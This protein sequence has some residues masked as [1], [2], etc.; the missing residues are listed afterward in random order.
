MNF[1]QIKEKEIFEQSEEMKKY[2]SNSLLCD[3]LS[4]RGILNVND[5]EKFLNSEKQS[6]STLDIF[7][8]GKK[9]S[10][11]I[12][13]AIEKQEKILVWG[14]F[15]ADGVTSCAL[16]HKTLKALGANFEV[17]IP[18]REKH[19]HGLNSKELLT[20]IAKHKVKVLITVDCGIS[21]IAE[22]KVAKSFGVDVIITDHH[23]VEGEIPNA[24]AILNP[25]AQGSL[26]EELKLDE[27][28]DY[29][30]LA[31]VGVAYKLAIDLLGQNHEICDELTV[32]ATV[33]TIS[34]VVPL[35]G[36]N[37]T[38]VT[39]GLKL[40]NNGVHTGIRMLFEANGR[41]NIT[42][43]DIAFI[44]TPR[45]NAIGRLTTPDLSFD[46]LTEQNESSLSFML[47]K[48]D[49][50]NK[51]RQG[52][53]DEIFLEAYDMVK[54]DKSFNKQK[55]IVLYKKGWH[56][57]IIGIVASKI[58][59]TFLKPVFIITS[60]D[61]KLARCSIRAQEGFNVYEILKRNSE[62]FE[63][64]GGHSLAGGFS[65]DLEKHSLEE[66]KNGILEAIDELGCESKQSEYLFVDK[67]LKPSEINL[68]LL[69]TISLLEPFGQD[70][71]ATV[72]ALKDLNVCESKF[73]GKNS[74]HLKLICKKDNEIFEC[75]K[76]RESELSLEQES[77]IDMAFVPR[78][79][80]FGDRETIQLEICDI[81]SEKLSKKT[82]AKVK[83]YDHRQKTGILK[84]ISDYL[85]GKDQDIAVWAKNLKTTNIL[86]NY[87]EIEKKYYVDGE[88]P[89]SIMFFDYPASY[90]NFEE[91]I[92]KIKPTKIHLMKDE[93]GST[94]EDTINTIKGMVK[95]AHNHKQGQIEISKM[96]QIC[97]VSEDFVQK[98]L[99]I[100]ENTGMIEILDIDEIKYLNPVS[101]DKVK[102]DPDFC[103]LEEEFKDISEFKK[104]LA[105]DSLDKMYEL[106]NSCL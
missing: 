88:K 18:S 35:L 17:F 27:I 51:I 83:I 85:K 1:R 59:E 14:D 43:T 33:G 100:L 78:L 104:H 74:D 54:N 37:R 25:Q 64:F 67:I 5:A 42:S 60:E 9:A 4:Q 48:L 87:P 73:I 94:L 12:K 39:K 84:Q 41:K 22:V 77:I 86:K 95:F 65:F 24:F 10:E 46:F 69:E 21:N 29:C 20:L 96:A 101:L 99:E 89:D 106:V 91:I 71:P 93:S 32:L 97:S 72:F 47:E 105:E 8:Q 2:L 81:Y 44:L 26:K 53:C 75:V 13:D 49:N 7:A 31:G 30:R 98:T 61:E 82:E 55:A 45:I 6:I 19:G 16:M 62:L 90:K 52:L 38:L 68:N 102:S 103:L 36:E 50:F 23:K 40:I 3:L 79:N 11:R 92:S 80:T 34:D 57:G 63:G 70:N 56:I 28:Q 76:W 15:D 66:V 58:M